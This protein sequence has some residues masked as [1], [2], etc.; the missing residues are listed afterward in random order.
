LLRG[1]WRAFD[2]TARLLGAPGA[3]LSSPDV[4]VGKNFLYVTTNIYSR[5]KVGGAVVRIPLSQIANG[6]PKPEIFASMESFGFRI[7]QNCTET[8]FFPSH[9]DTSTITVHSWPEQE[10]VP[11]WQDVPVAQW[12]GGTGYDSRCP[13]GRRWLDRVDPRLTG[14]TK[15]GSELFF[16]WPVDAGSN[17]RPNPFIQ[18]ARI[19]SWELKLIENIYVFDAESATC[20]PALATNVDNEVAI[21]YMIGGGPRFPSHAV[22]MLTRPRKAILVAPGDRGPDPDPTTGAGEWGDYL[23]LRPVPPENKL[24]AAAACTLK[25]KGDGSRLDATPHF[26]VVGRSY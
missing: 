15:A 19:D 24:F 21:S 9:K 26:A 12:V 8:A 18:V 6:E 14:A 4:A 20:Y 23:T 5:T 10:R 25:G 22:G 11:V 17:Q 2:I 7:C 1:Q 16:A 13:D 3:V